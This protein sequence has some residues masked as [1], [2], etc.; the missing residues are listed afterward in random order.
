MKNIFNV[1]NQFCITAL[2]ML[3]TGSFKPFLFIFLL[4]LIHELGHIFMAKLFGFKII[5][6]TLFPFGALTKLDMKIN[7]SI[8][9][10]L[11]IAL[12]GPTF[13]MIGY[14]FLKTYFDF[15]EIHYFLLM[16]NLLPIYPLD[17]SK[18]LADILYLFTPFKLVTNIIVIISTIISLFFYTFYLVNFKLIYL[19]AFS[20]L[21]NKIFEL[22]KLRKYLF[23]AF[24]LEKINY[25]FKYPFTR[26][27]KNIFNMYKC[28]FHYIYNGETFEEER[29][30]LKEM[31][32]VNT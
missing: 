21:I 8:F 14:S 31:Y 11:L 17:G 19:I 18:L 24:L 13:Q 23:N 6:V 10:D 32:K 26:K 12:A 30:Y 20:L 5:S 3:I 1:T 4:V 7:D 9:K 2:I 28:T 15:H 22:Y 16:F 27:I 29:A 25:N